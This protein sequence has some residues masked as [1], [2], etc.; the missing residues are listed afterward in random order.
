[1]KIKLIS[2]TAAL[3]TVS[4]IGCASIQSAITKARA[5][6]VKA[7]AF[8]ADP[9]N[10]ADIKGSAQAVVTIATFLAPYSKNATLSD[11]ISAARVAGNAYS[12]NVPTNVLQAT[13]ESLAVTKA[14]GPIVTSGG[15]LATMNKIVDQATEILN[16]L[17]Q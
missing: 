16:K 17:P 10:Q 2:I 15:N 6:Y 12:N 1:M 3:L 14:I 9:A 4:L 11:A 13:T 7:N 8:L 5:E